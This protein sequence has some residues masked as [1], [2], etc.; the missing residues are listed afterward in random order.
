MRM[1]SLTLSNHSID[2]IDLRA[3]PGVR[4]SLENPGPT[5]TR[6]SRGTSAFSNS[7]AQG[8]IARLVY[9]SSSSVDAMYVDT[10]FRWRTAPTP[11]SRYMRRRNGPMTAQRNLRPS[12]PDT[13]KPDFAFSRFTARGAARHGGLE[14]HWSGYSGPDDRRFG[15]VRSLL[16][17]LNLLIERH[18]R[19][20]FRRDEYWNSLLRG[21][22]VCQPPVFPYRD[23]MPKGYRISDVSKDEAVFAAQQA[24]ETIASIA[25]RLGI[26]RWNVS[27]D[28]T[29]IRS[30]RRLE[31]RRAEFADWRDVPIAYSGLSTRAQD[32]I[33]AMR[34][35]TMGALYVALENEGAGLFKYVPNVGRIT[36]GEIFAWYNAKL[37]ELPSPPRG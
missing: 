35:A 4:Y 3:Q 11:P 24:G 10:P 17:G 32:T 5:S 8:K 20:L 1:R 37:G 2:R 29:R 27:A 28:C 23:D 14:V 31:S 33:R 16:S 22:R 9:A 7:R 12:L 6:T 19:A 18:V 30:R 21:P 34:I 13:P 26:N 25:D 15:E 36:A